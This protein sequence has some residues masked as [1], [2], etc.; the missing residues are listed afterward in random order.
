MPT[1]TQIWEIS[2]F[3][4]YARNP[5]KNDSAVNRMVSSIN[6]FGFKI[7]VLARSDGEVVDG[8]FD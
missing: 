8:I 6:E 3:V 7:P 2:R 5:R 1:E 4:P